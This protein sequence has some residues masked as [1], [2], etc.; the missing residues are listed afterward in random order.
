LSL[1]PFSCQPGSRHSAPS[2]LFSY[3]TS[4]MLEFC[5]TGFQQLL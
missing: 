3:S 4:I 1:R 5:A 2:S